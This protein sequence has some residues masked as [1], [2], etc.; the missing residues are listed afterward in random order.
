MAPKF[1]SLETSGTVRSTLSWPSSALS[2]ASFQ[3]PADSVGRGRRVPYPQGALSPTGPAVRVVQ[4]GKVW[5][6]SGR[7]GVRPQKS[8]FLSL[9]P[10]CPSMVLLGRASGEHLWGP[11]GA[12][13][14]QALDLYLQAPEG[15]GAPRGDCLEDLGPADQRVRMTSGWRR[16]GPRAAL[17][18]RPAAHFKC[19]SVGGGGTSALRSGRTYVLYTD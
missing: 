15:Q 4:G 7:M 6:E 5:V 16:G 14:L 18:A 10:P 13:G 19:R 9:F 11:A 17:S 1:L 12:G 8:H 3:A 2:P